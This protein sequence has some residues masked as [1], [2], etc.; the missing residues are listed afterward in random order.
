MGVNMFDIGLTGSEERFSFDLEN[1]FFASNPYLPERNYENIFFEADSTD[2]YYEDEADGEKQPHLPAQK[3]PR[4]P[5]GPPVGRSAG[6]P[7]PS[8]AK[9]TPREL[10]TI[11]EPTPPNG[12]LTP[13]WYWHYDQNAAT[14]NEA[15]QRRSLLNVAQPIC[16]PF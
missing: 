2:W 14:H 6:P 11:P 7:A 15:Y 5:R 13:L 12:E 16:G 9:T 8:S 3:P 10:G 4:K 1:A